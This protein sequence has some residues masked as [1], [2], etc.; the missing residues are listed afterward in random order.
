M[1][2]RPC[3]YTRIGVTTRPDCGLGDFSVVLL[4]LNGGENRVGRRIEGPLGCIAIY[5][6]G[7]EHGRAGGGVLYITH[8]QLSGHGTPG[9]AA[10]GR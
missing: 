2:S 4:R 7:Q 5:G 9:R 3:C 10:A 8:D 6:W 1:V